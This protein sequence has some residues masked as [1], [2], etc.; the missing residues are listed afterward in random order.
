MDY[1][2][3]GK[4]FYVQTE[5]PTWLE[6]AYAEPINSS[7]TGIVAR[8]IQNTKLV[9]STL[10][11]LGARK[12]R[13]VDCA[14]GY[15]LL[16]RMLRD[17]GIDALWSDQYATNLVCKGF[18]YQGGRADLVTAFEA[19]EHFVDP[20]YEIRRLASISPNILFTTSLIPSPAPLPDEWWYYGLEHGQHIGFFRTKTL[21]Y[22]ASSL[23]LYL[24]SDQRSVHLLSKKPISMKIWWFM[25]NLAKLNLSIFTKGLRSRTWDDH[26]SLINPKIYV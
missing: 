17:K 6:K 3:C 15:G 13:V 2:E 14:G 19:F 24:A 8:N 1:F 12:G 20:D 22:L 26:L 23:N 25:R 16:V 4:C 5:K 10:S 9:I 7:D 18:E 11:V 21:E